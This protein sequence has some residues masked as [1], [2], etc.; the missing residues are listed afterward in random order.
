MI[1]PIDDRHDRLIRFYARL[2]G[3]AANVVRGWVYLL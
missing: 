1:D 2:F 3:E